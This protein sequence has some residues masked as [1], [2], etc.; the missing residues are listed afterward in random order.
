M[1]NEGSAVVSINSEVKQDGNFSV[2]LNKSLRVFF[3]DALRITVKNPLQAYFFL[4]TVIRQK[5]AAG[6]TRVTPAAPVGRCPI[7]TV[8]AAGRRGD[9]LRS[10]AGPVHRSPFR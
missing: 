4:K 7:R 8:L 10:P 3:K 2:L 9:A 1:A 5:R 6:V